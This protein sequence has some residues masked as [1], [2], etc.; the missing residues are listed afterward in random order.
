LKEDSKSA[1]PLSSA[2]NNSSFSRMRNEQREDVEL[3]RE[4]KALIGKQDTLRSFY[5]ST[6]KKDKEAKTYTWQGVL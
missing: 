3:G 6:Q 4:E 5:G 2:S 1:R